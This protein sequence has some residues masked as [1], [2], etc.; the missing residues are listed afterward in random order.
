MEKLSG[1]QKA[2][3]IQKIANEFNSS[4]GRSL[5]NLMPNSRVENEIKL[6]AMI[7]P[8]KN[9]VDKVVRII[10]PRN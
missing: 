2:N 3:Y 7:D 4:L 1:L 10:Y 6:R 5:V 9:N 8:K